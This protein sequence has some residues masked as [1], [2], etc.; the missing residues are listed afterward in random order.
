M[1]LDES[2]VD[3]TYLINTTTLKAENEDFIA[4]NFLKRR[5]IRQANTPFVVDGKVIGLPFNLQ[6]V[7][8]NIGKKIIPDKL[9]I[10]HLFQD[11]RLVY[12]GMSKNVRNRLLGH[13][14]DDDMPF[15]NCLWFISSEFTKERT[16]KEI[17]NIE[18]NM[19]K[20]FRPIFNIQYVNC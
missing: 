15:N 13:L 11:D 3:P 4:N 7:I 17:F 14:I 2:L 19:I 12:I 20:R 5:N 18:R 6:D 1:I 10:Y 16:V 8:N 9:G